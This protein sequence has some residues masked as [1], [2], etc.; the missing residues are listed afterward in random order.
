MKEEL[1]EPVKLNDSKDSKRKAIVFG[2]VFVFVILFVIIIALT[3]YKDDSEEKRAS[4][5]NSNIENHFNYDYKYVL[6][7]SF[8]AEYFIYLLNDDTVKV[9]GK[10]PV[11]ENCP[12]MN[13][14]ELTGEFDYEETTIEFSEKSMV[15][16]RD[17]I[18]GLFDRK[19]TNYLNLETVELTKKQKIIEMALL[20]NHED[21]ITFEDSLIF[22]TKNKQ[23]KNSAGK[24]VFENSKTTIATSKNEIVNQIASYLN[25]I[26]ENEWALLE[27]EFQGLLSEGFIFS[28]EDIINFTLKLEDLNASTVSFIY[29][30][31]GTFNSTVRGDKKAY[32]FNSA[33]GEVMEYPKG[34]KEPEKVI[35]SF[36]NSKDYESMQ[37]SLM[38]NWETVFTENMYKPGYWYLKDDKIIF[39]IPETLISN[40]PIRDHIIEL[41]IENTHDNF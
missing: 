8:G 34:W 9:V 6:Q 18:T 22:E 37:D 5:S 40:S 41:E 4:N 39:L 30:M 16:V 19:L 28:G 26:V 14:M 31:N 38:Q 35:E 25:A 17:F 27:E 33:N 2:I 32:V 20:L 7:T 11:A 1:N 12:E 23:L 36:K 29:S 13:C 10:I 21:M 15:K 24:V 3:L